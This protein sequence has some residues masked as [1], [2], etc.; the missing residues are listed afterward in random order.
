MSKGGALSR[1]GP[2]LAVIG[3]HIAII[4]VLSVSMGVVEMPK[5]AVPLRRLQ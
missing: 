5:I 2:A 3:I 4:Y 1:G